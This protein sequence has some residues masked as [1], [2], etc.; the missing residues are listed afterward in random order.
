MMIAMTGAIGFIGKH[1]DRVL[2]QQEHKV[3]KLERA[4]PNRAIK[5]LSRAMSG[6]DAVVKLTCT[7]INRHWTAVYKRE[8]V[9]SQVETT[10]QLVQAM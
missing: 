9:S 8:V 10:Q 2:R 5:Y 6:S 3:V 7:P 4:D 1:F